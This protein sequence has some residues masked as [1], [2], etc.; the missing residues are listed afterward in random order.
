[1]L[2]LQCGGISTLCESSASMQSTIHLRIV[3]HTLFYSTD[4]F[5]SFVGR[6]LAI[7]LKSCN[8]FLYFNFE[9][10]QLH[11][12]NTEHS[13]FKN[14]QTMG[15]SKHRMFVLVCEKNLYFSLQ[16]QRT[17]IKRYRNSTKPYKTV[18]KFNDMQLSIL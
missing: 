11:S 2:S 5:Y 8:F 13:P 7:D 3:G 4:H 9:I 6:S 18:Q 15:N 10:L 16:I 12:E 14:Q 1:M 17:L